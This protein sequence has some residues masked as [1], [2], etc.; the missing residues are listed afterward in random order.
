MYAAM[1]AK[2]GG[3]VRIPTLPGCIVSMDF[4]IRVHCLVSKHADSRGKW[5]RIQE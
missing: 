5:S 1:A 4:M 3:P 2:K